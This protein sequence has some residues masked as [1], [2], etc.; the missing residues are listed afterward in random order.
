QQLEVEDINIRRTAITA[1]G[2]I[3]D[4][5]SVP[6]LIGLLDDPELCVEAAGA[7]AHIGDRRAYEPLLPLLAHERAAVRQ[8]A[9]AAL[10]SLGHPDMPKD[11]R[12]LLIGPH[13]H[14]REGAVRIAGFFGFTGCE[15]LLIE[16]GH[17]VDENVRRA[18]IES[19]LNFEDEPFVPLLR[20]PIRDA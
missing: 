6:S 20:S 19:L 14:I 1:L 4:P 10:N 7:L 15:A 2:R 12:H 11:L 16:R 13:P 17:D 8:A 5:A 18:V 9:I 3:G